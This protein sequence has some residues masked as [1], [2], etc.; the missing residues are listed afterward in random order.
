MRN[1]LQHYFLP[2]ECQLEAGAPGIPVQLLPEQSDVQRLQQAAQNL[3]ILQKRRFSDRAR[4]RNS[5][6]RI[7]ENKIRMY[8][9]LENIK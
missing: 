3:P 4:E 6:R 9:L 1:L 8:S 2:R 5:D 7:Q